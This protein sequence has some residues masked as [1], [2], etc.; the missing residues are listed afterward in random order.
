MAAVNL[1]GMKP[2]VTLKGGFQRQ[3]IVL[4]V[5]SSHTNTQPL[6]G[7][8]L[9][10]LGRGGLHFFLFVRIFQIAAGDQFLPD[11]RQIPFGFDAG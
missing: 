10:G 11:F 9:H 1:L 7:Y 5:I 3:Q 8:K 6:G 2:D 4:T